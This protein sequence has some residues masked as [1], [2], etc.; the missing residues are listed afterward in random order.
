MKI[1]NPK[2]LE[3]A[4]QLKKSY[5]EAV[6]FAGGTYVYS[7]GHDFADAIDISRVVR[8]EIYH[9]MNHVHIGAMATLEKILLSELS[10]LILRK[11]AKLCPSLQQRSAA[12]I[13]GNIAQR[14]D[15]GYLTAAVL[16]SEPVI[17]L[18]TENGRLEVS[19]D[20]YMAGKHDGLILEFIFRKNLKGDVKRIGRTSHMHMAVSGA[21][22]N[23]VYAYTASS[24][25]FAKG[26][27][28]SW[29][30]IAF[31]SDSLGSADYKRY[32]LSVMF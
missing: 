2:S 12:T 1:H 13:G 20:D 31:E 11:G 32:L 9:T 23:G 10:P 26:G 4:V 28:D 25:G 22:C 17:V 21:E 29:Q 3:E 8:N 5:P 16:A 7:L 15:D 30:D 27:K 14:R 6:Y 18:M 24:S 19:A